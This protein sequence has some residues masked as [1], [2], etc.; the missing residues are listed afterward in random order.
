M[1]TLKIPIDIDI[2]HSDILIFTRPCLTDWRGF[3]LLV[4][5]GSS[6]EAQVQ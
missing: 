6:V 4:L 3:R 1:S 2:I 5:L